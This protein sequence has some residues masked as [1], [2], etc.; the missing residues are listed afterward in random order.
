[1]RRKRWE[2]LVCWLVAICSAARAAEPSAMTDEQIRS[3]LA[4]S[5]LPNPGYGFEHYDGPPGR[6]FEFI[7]PLYLTTGGK[8]LA[9]GVIL[10]PFLRLFHYGRTHAC[11]EVSLD[12]ARTLAGN[13]TWVVLWRL[14]DPPRP[15]AAGTTGDQ[16]VLTPTEVRW[17]SGGAWH[18]PVWTRTRDSWMS[19][20]F[21]RDWNERSSL[22]AAFATLE[23][24]GALHA[25][26]RVTEN[27]R[28]Y[29]TEQAI[30]SLTLLREKWW[31]AASEPPPEKESKP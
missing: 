3:V 18:E 22:L 8:K 15:F 28:S 24:D 14:E 16:K 10:P 9:Y 2:L 25:D 17:R 11:D 30:F 26:Y 19:S 4:R 29:L 7:G 21:G 23:H 13:E 31:Q 5:C 27:G 12:E 1:M 20:W 6:D